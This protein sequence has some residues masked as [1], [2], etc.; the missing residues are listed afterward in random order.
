MAVPPAQTPAFMSHWARSQRG[1]HVMPV[2]AV[3]FWMKQPEGH[4]HVCSAMPVM[5][6]PCAAASC[7]AHR[8]RV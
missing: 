5:F 7:A 6:L 8:H 1:V 4:S 3:P 2:S